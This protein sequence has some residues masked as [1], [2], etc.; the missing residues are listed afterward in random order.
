MTISV[1]IPVLREAHI[2]DCITRLRDVGA[3][4]IIVVDGDEKKSTIKGIKDIRV[5]TT[6]SSPGRAKQMNAGAT[7]A[8]GDALLFLHADTRLPQ[9]AFAQ[10]EETLKKT[11]AGGFIMRFTPTNR[12]LN[13]IAGGTS[14]R[15]R[16]TRI[17]RGDQAQ[18]FRKEYFHKIGGYQ[19][20]PL[21]ED[22]EIMKRIRKQG[23]NITLINTPVQT[24]SRRYK[25][26]G[27]IRRTLKNWLIITL[28]TLGMK[29][30]KLVG[31]Y[32]SH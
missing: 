2:N 9:N 30:Q 15:S 25:K 21:F 16:I 22:V 29:P 6:V 32:R 10:V 19:E 11:P 3:C 14:L 28:Y 13:I 8:T 1:I 7:I 17:P 12:L 27:I 24:S 26:E 4:E 18:F 5:K 23:D 20:I 31:L